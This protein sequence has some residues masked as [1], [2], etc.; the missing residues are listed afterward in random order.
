MPHLVGARPAQD[1]PVFRQGRGA[2]GG[3]VRRLIH[4]SVEFPDE[5]SGPLVLGSGRFM[6]LGLMRPADRPAENTTADDG[7]TGEQSGDG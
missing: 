4:A 2:S 6:G 5:V 7:A 1:F 3:V